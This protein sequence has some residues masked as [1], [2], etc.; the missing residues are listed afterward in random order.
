MFDVE[1]RFRDYISENF[2]LNKEYLNSNI[3][4]M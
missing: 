4:E 1:E 2:N 3:C